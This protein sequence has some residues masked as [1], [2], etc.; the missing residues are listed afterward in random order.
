MTVGALVEAAERVVIQKVEGERFFSVVDIEVIVSRLTLERF[1]GQL[2]AFADRERGPD[3]KPDYQPT[4]GFHG[5]FSQEVMKVRGSRGCGVVV[6]GGC[7]V[8]VFALVSVLIRLFRCLWP[9]HGRA[10]LTT[11]KWRRASTPQR[12]T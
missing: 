3:D 1:S 9:T 10:L 8:S 2:A 4:L 5:A 12:V 11:G 6:S 7:V